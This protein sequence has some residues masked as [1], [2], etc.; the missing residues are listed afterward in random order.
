MEGRHEETALG[1]NAR[2]MEYLMRQI[3]EVTYA[4][5]PISQELAEMTVRVAECI[6]VQIAEAGV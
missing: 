5:Q 3:L 6:R 1:R 4:G 2:W